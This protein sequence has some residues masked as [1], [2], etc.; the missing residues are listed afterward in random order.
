MME[1]MEWPIER[2]ELPAMCDTDPTQIDPAAGVASRRTIIGAAVAVLGL[3]SVSKARAQ[4]ATPEPIASLATPETVPLASPVAAPDEALPY[5]FIQ[6]GDQGSWQPVRGQPGA[7]WFTLSDPSPQTIVIR[8]QPK[9]AAGTIATALFFDSIF[10]D[11]SSPLQ[12]VI[13]AQTPTGEDVLVVSLHRAT[14]DPTAGA[15]SY[16]ATKLD[17]YTDVHGLTP[18][19]GQTA[20]FTLPPT[21]GATTL[22]I[23]NAYCRTA[24]GATCQFG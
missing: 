13:S 19:Q 9:N 22:F 1:G 5:L 16:I 4:N 23:T 20:N 2:K 6:T 21:F 15:L 7:F 17:D 14:Y 10:I 11:Q 12:G 3:V 18:L 24:G 8:D